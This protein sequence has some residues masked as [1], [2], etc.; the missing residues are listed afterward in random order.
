MFW[1]Y[2]IY[3]SS[4]ILY[5][6]STKSKLIFKLKT[7]PKCSLNAHFQLNSL[8]IT[9]FKLNVLK[10]KSLHIFLKDA[11]QMNDRPTKLPQMQP[12]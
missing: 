8:K 12:K 5:T 11:L 7:L 3:T 1:S 10:L 4:Y 2:D 9:N 6:A